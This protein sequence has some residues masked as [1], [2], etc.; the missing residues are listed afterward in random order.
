MRKRRPKARELAP[1][2]RYGD[3][4]V[5]RFVNNLMLRGKKSTG[6]RLFYQSMDLIKERTDE[7]EH[8]IF[9]SSAVKRYTTGRSAQPTCR[10]INIPDPDGD[11]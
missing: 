7:N 10:W 2:P 11:P 3:P 9:K 5:T 8:E 6:Y 1:D 4:V